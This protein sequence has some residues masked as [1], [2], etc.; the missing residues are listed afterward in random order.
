MIMF[1]LLL[2][3]CSK[4]GPVQ[5]MHKKLISNIETAEID[6]FA[7]TCAP[8]NFAI[9]IANKEFAELEFEQGDIH[10]AEDH[11]L[12]AQKNITISIEKPT[13]APHTIADL[14]A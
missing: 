3:G 1:L 5:S 10:R 11:L 7:R 2:V 13:N 12:K 9:A 6:D 4:Y 14:H 8:E